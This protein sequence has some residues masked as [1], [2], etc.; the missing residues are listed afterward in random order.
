MTAPAA[1]AGAAV[2]A[3]FT[4]PFTGRARRELL[5]CV[6]GLPLSLPLPV[7]GFA[8]TI[9]LAQV[10]GPPWTADGNPSWLA[11]LTAAAV[12]VLTAALMVA[13]GAHPGAG[14]GRPQ[15]RGQAARRARGHAASA[16]HPARRRPGLAGDGLPDAEAPGRAGRVVRRRRLLG[17]R[18]RQPDLPVLV[19]VVPQPLPGRA[20]EPGPGDH[21]VQLVRRG[22]PLPG[23]DVPR[24]VRRVRRRRRHAAGRPVGDQGSGGRRPLAHPRPARPGPPHPAGARP[25]ADPGAGGG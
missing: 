6:L 1:A 25:G 17:G 7:V 14:R 23:H 13:T 3:P 4:A 10:A 20:A 21:P 12:V 15:N 18:D 24:H 9:W 8:V 22:R 11:L 16:T 19:A 5:F 2:R